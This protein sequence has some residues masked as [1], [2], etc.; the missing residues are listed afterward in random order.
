MGGLNKRNE[1]LTIDRISD[2]CVHK[3]FCKKIP[4]EG[5]ITSRILAFPSSKDNRTNDNDH[6]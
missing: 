4:L 3:G 2:L 6:N 1:R 5:E